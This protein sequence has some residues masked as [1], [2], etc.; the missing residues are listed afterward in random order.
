MTEVS[1]LKRGCAVAF[2]AGATS[3][4]LGV[5]THPDAADAAAGINP[6]FTVVLSNPSIQ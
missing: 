5:Q 1:T 2:Q 3:A 6:D 4:T